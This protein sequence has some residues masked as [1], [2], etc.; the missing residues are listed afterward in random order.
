MFSSW[1]MYSNAPQR[2]NFT[3]NVT[4][5]SFF[6]YPW[7]MQSTKK[8]GSVNEMASTHGSKIVVRAGNV[9]QEVRS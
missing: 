5:E 1:Y 8:R 2:L 7:L 3:G 9:K 6:V 4:I